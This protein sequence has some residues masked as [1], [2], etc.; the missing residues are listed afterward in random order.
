M[1]TSVVKTILDP[2]AFTCRNPYRF[3]FGAIATSS[4]ESR[5]DSFSTP[6]GSPSPDQASCPGPRVRRRSA[7]FLARCC[8][9]VSS[10]RFGA[11]PAVRDLVQREV[12]RELAC[13]VCWETVQ[14]VGAGQVWGN[15]A[16][17]VAGKRFRGLDAPHLLSDVYEGRNLRDGR[18]VPTHQPKAAA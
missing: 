17:A 14:T 12:E 15:S 1:T 13:A 5:V 6:R 16:R 3:G 9:T 18:P 8:I 4:T 10:A 2:P 7:M 11:A